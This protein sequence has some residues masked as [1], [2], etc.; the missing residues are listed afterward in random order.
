MHRLANH[1]INLHQDQP[2]QQINQRDSPPDSLPFNLH[3]CQQWYPVVNQLNLLKLHQLLNL[4]GNPA[5]CRLLPQLICRVASLL[6]LLQR[7]LQEFQLLALPVSQLR[8]QALN[9]LASLPLHQPL[10]HHHPQQNALHLNHQHYRVHS[11]RLLRLANPPL[12]QVLVRLVSLVDRQLHNQADNHRCNL[13]VNQRVF[14]LPFHLLSHR[15]LLQHSHPLDHQY[16]QLVNPP[17]SPVLSLRHIHL[18]LPL[19]NQVSNQ[20]DNLQR[21]LLLSHRLNQLVNHLPDQV[22]NHLVNQAANRL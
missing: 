22:L 7:S 3:L 18:L 13:V 19:L 5:L 6:R 20:V 4:Q 17:R 10:N 2:I 12:F 8:S 14:R 9:H 11:L 1:Q 21:I 15:H 16:N